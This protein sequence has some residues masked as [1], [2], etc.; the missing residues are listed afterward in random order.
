MDRDVDDENGTK[1][2]SATNAPVPMGHAQ[3]SVGAQATLP[4]PQPPTQTGF[5]PFQNWPGF[6]PTTTVS[7]RF[8][9]HSAGLV[10][11]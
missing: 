9:S 8:L 7:G 1:L 5:G 3:G 2:A 10:Y 4:V 11:L 6:T